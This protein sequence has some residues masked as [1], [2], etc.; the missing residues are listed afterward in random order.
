MTD[1]AWFDA[2]QRG[3]LEAMREALRDQRRLQIRDV[4]GQTA[5]HLA[6]RAGHPAVVALLLAHGA[7]PDVEDENGRTPLLLT[8]VKGHIA[9]LGT[10]LDYGAVAGFRGGSDLTALDVAAFNGHVAAVEL[11]VVRG[12]P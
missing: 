11:L 4:D 5:L 9:A 6:A 8:A 2:A 3:D 1:R 12:P 10:L 7:P